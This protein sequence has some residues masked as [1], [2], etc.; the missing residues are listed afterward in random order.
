MECSAVFRLTDWQDWQIVN[1]NI[2]PNLRD[3]RASV[4]YSGATRELYNDLEQTYNS[5]KTVVP[6]LSLLEDKTTQGLLI[7]ESIRKFILP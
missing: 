5:H 3:F 4:P 1:S 2:L 7:I 6:Y